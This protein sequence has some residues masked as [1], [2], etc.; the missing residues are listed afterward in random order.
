LSEVSIPNNRA[1]VIAAYSALA[2]ISLVLGHFVYS[3]VLAGR[4]LAATAIICTLLGPS[5]WLIH[6]IVGVPMFLAA[7]FLIVIAGVLALLLLR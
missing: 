1:I 5:A 7:T 3:P 6:G 2:C 4:L